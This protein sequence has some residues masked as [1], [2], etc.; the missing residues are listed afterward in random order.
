MTKPAKPRIVIIGIGNIFLSDEGVG[1]HAISK[2]LNEWEFP[3]N[4]E[5]YDGGVTGMMGLLPIIEDT[6]HLIV[7]D[8]VN[9]GDPPGY[10]RT[11]TLGDFRLVMPKKLSAHDIGFLECIAIAEINGKTPKSV[12]V[13]GIKPVDIETPRNVLSDIVDSKLAE[14]TEITIGELQ[15]LGAIAVKRQFSSPSF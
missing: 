5:V 4:V 13:I 6:D 15:K 8:V 9:S 3:S 2:L 7:I 1:V 12:T 14:I 11:Y 10:I